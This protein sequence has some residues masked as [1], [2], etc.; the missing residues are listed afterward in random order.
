MSVST[1]NPL[2]IAEVGDYSRCCR[3]MIVGTRGGV[4]KSNTIRRVSSDRRWSKGEVLAMQ[5][6]PRHLDPSQDEE[7]TLISTELS[8][9]EQVKV[10]ARRSRN[11]D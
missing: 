8:K 4:A 7:S 9:D 10:H 2:E 1:A 6:V 5:G 3:A 11:R